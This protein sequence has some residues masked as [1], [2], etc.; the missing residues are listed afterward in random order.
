MAEAALKIEEVREPAFVRRFE[1]A[2]LSRHGSWLMK[3][4]TA[5]L[6]DV[7]EQRIGGYLRGLLFDNE[8]LFLYQDHAVALFQVVYSPGIKPVK[9]VQERFVWAENR[10][11]KTQLEMAADFYTHA[12]AWAKRMGAERIIACEDSDVSKPLII[13]RI[14]RLFDTT[15]SHARVV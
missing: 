11:D 4:F 14:G 7:H 6:P 2:D 9:V 13:A 10:A 5:K 1:L 3:R 8:H 12:L 15:I